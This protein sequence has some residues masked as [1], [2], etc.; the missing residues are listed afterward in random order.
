MM[1]ILLAQVILLLLETFQLIFQIIDYQLFRDE[2]RNFKQTINKKAQQ[3][4]EQYTTRVMDNFLRVK[5][6]LKWMAKLQ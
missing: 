4:I 3:S 6:E 1:V 2:T 5:F